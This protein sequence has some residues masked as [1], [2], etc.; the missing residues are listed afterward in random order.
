M[1]FFSAEIFIIG[2]N[3]Y[4]L[5][6]EKILKQ[7]FKQAQKDKGPVPVRGTLNGHKYKQTLVKY[8]GKWR[9]YL[10]TPMR[11]AAAIDVGD[12]ARVKIEF[13]PSERTLT[14]H[15]KLKIALQK[16]KTAL[17]VFTAQSPS[18]QKEIIRYINF[19]KTE[20]SVDRNVKRAIAFLVGKERFVGRNKP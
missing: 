10:N 18:R 15:P 7:L 16:N 12:I 19:L 20:E 3:P 4:V 5:P 1:N 2:V 14:M 13:D 6:P 11:K 17:Q 8:S 9:L